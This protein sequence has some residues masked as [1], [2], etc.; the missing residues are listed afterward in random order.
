MRRRSREFMALARENLESARLVVE[1]ELFAPAISDAY[2][3]MVNAAR[4]ALSEEDR[5][6]RTH[7]GLWH[8]L[9][10]IH[11]GPTAGCPRT[12]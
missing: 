8:L 1:R 11:V 9:R 12:S 10:E 3:A 5:Y 6:S 2:Y 7:R 4:A